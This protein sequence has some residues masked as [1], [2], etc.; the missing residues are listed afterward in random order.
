M[1]WSF[2]VDSEGW[3]LDSRDSNDGSLDWSASV[4]SPNLGALQ[5]DTT[6]QQLP[7]VEESLGDLRGA[8]VVTRV[9]VESGNG[10]SVKLFAQSGVNHYWADGGAVLPAIGEWTCLSLDVDSPDFKTQ[11]FDSS[12]VVSVGVQVSATSPALVYID[13][14]GF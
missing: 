10:V 5:V 8:V 12:D 14:V 2:D 9:L 13:Q 7:K 4:G 1:G 3:F 6:L 11:Q